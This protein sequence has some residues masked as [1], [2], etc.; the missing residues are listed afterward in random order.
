M[1]TM[2]K[3]T[4]LLA[5]TVLGCA[6]GAGTNQPR[7]A[8]PAAVLLAYAPQASPL[9]YV[10]VDSG[11]VRMEIP[12]MGPMDVAFNLS[13]TSR[14]ALASGSDGLD[15]TINLT[16]L[17]GQMS[18]PQTGTTGVDNT[19]IPRDPARVS[20][21]RA[22]GITRTAF[23]ELSRSL[24]DVTTAATLFRTLFVRLPAG[25]VRPGATWVDTVDV[26]DQLG[27]LNMTQRH[28]LH[29][30]YVG[31]TVIAGRR[32]AR[33]DATSNIT[34]SVTGDANGMQIEQRLIGAGRQSVL[35]D[36]ARGALVERRFENNATG[37]MTVVGAGI[38]DIPMTQRSRTVTRLREGG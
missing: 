36:A 16:E 9:T 11:N 1:I 17:S 20:V 31:D 22:G 34:M 37:S 12:Q 26:S 19:M 33:I 5:A 21:T 8:S 2:R 27:G 6:P 7:G 23:P 30:T 32:L 35:W 18:N 29:S 28:E 3:T 25:A 4:L 14:L 38:G 13:A 15:A 24:R 10:T